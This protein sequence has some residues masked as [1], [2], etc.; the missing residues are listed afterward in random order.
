M[1]TILETER[2]MERNKQCASIE[3]NKHKLVFC[4]YKWPVVKSTTTKKIT[5]KS[6]YEKQTKKTTS[7]SK[8]QKIYCYSF[9]WPSFIYFIYLR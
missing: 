9:F 5:V 7:K 2:E 4:S 3:F 1:L 8:T 6:W